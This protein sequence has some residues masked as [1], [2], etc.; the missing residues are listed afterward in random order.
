MIACIEKG[1]GLREAIAAE[2]L[3]LRQVDGVW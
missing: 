2:G 3:S 1:Y